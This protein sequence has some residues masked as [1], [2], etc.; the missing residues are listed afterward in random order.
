MPVYNVAPYLEECV[1]SIF[2]QEADELFEVIMLD[3]GS[4]DNSLEIAQRLSA[5]Y[6]GRLTVL[7]HPVNKGISA[8]RNGVLDAARGTYIWHV[9]PD[10]WMF[11]SALKQLFAILKKEEPDLVLCDFSKKAGEKTA[12]FVGAANSLEHDREAL[13]FGIFSPRK[14]HCWSKISK[15]SLWRGAS[16]NDLRF[17]DGKVFEDISST[18]FLL[19]RA[20]TY[21]YAPE[22]W[23]FY[24]QR[25]D[26]I[27]GLMS[28]GKG[29]DEVRHNQLAHALVGFKEKLQAELG[30]VHPDTQFAIAH[31]VARS[32]SQIG[33]KLLRERMFK[34]SWR[35]TRRMMGEYE[36]ITQSASILTFAQLQKAYRKRGIY[37]RA[38]VLGLF[39]L[40]SVQ[41]PPRPV[42][43][44]DITKALFVG[45]NTDL[46]VEPVAKTR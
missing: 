3:D 35:K 42:A 40:I 38:A 26:S 29:F 30:N 39:R 28:R 9:D 31:F 2:S 20:R 8:A 15:R 17:P 33:F 25:S 7:R 5:Q 36:A 16:G 43:E 44:S 34:Q 46:S 37:L 14:M 19:L 12:S 18:P 32:F 27:L 10:D 4:T 11:P 45:E 6:D 23:I 24:R 13:V 22:T 41:V 21:Y 1:H